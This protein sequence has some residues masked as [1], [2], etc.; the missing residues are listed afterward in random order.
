MLT[1][2][3][4]I[5]FY[6]KFYKVKNMMLPFIL[7]LWVILSFV[8]SPVNEVFTGF[9]DII[10]HK[11]ILLSD[12]TAIGG[13]GAAFF[14]S[15]LLM[16]ASY[17]ILKVLDMRITGPI[18]AG[19]LTIGGFAFFGKNILNVGIIYLGVYLYTRY[20]KISLKSVIII[21]LFASGI[22]P[23][24]SLL[25]FG[26]G[27]PLYYSIPLGIA[28][29]IAAG[30][31]IV[32]LSVHAITFHKGFDLYNVGFAGGIISIIVIAL[33][34]FSPL[35]YTM[36]TVYVTDYHLFFF[37]LFILLDVFFMVIGFTYNEKSLKGYKSLLKLSGRAVTD[38]TRHNHYAITLFNVGL[39]G[40]IVLTY[41][42]ILGIQISG[43]VAGALM[44]V[45]GFAAF[46]KHIKNV[47][48]SMLGVTIMAL[49]L[50]YEFTHIGV[51]LAIIFSTGLAP[52]SGEHGPVY[53]II[54]GML[55]LP[56]V[57]SFGELLGGVQLYANGFSAA[58]TAVLMNTLI[59]TVKKEK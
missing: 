10:T 43:P 9:I 1:R 26:V 59:S 8:V 54:G 34:N 25:M 14:N 31:L 27:L 30:M 19:I 16:I 58:F 29:G 44:T 32:E 7:L 21:M 22:A 47:V 41:I 20:K 48:P 2:S 37:I 23:M 11:S 28:V 53:G 33:I 49:V 57:F 56:L 6:A 40:L 5:K 39:T 12:Y 38:F 3:D 36:D 42:T 45:M 13:L 35:S 4:I 17:A 18:F 52:L 51:S 46:G 55:H 24:V 15:A 50:G